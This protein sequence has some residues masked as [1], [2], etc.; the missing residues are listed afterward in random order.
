MPTR[1]SWNDEELNDLLLRYDSGETYNEIARAL[2]RSYAAVQSRIWK[3][4]QERQLQENSQ[5]NININDS[6]SNGKE[7]ADTDHENEKENENDN[8]SNNR[9]QKKR[10]RNEIELMTN[11]E[12]IKTPIINKQNRPI[13]SLTFF[14]NDNEPKPKRRKLTNNKD[15]NE[16]ISNWN[17]DRVIIWIESIVSISDVTRQQFQEQE[18]DGK[19]LK[20]MGKDDLLQL[21]IKK[22][23]DRIVIIQERD[24]LI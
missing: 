15:N 19:T 6:L 8:K 13:S 11:D 22:L 18:I 5:C 21:G 1:S 16:D 12:L 2:N 3:L 9:K 23:Y 10:K 20:I 17:I 24:K 7:E 4:K 14:F